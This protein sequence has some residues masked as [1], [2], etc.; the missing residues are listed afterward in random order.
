MFD[1]QLIVITSAGRGIGV[2]TAEMFGEAGTQVVV[3]GLDPEPTNS[4]VAKIKATGG[5]LNRFQKS[6]GALGWSAL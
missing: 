5:D 1:T 2:A 6:I 4:V 3:N